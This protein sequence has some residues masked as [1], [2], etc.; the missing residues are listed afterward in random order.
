M[1]APVCV[2]GGGLT[3]AACALAIAHDGWDV[4][5]VDRNAPKRSP[6][7]LGVEIR[8]VALSPASRRL[9]EDLGAWI[10]GAPYKSMHVWEERGTA[11]ID[12]DADDAGVDTLGWIVEVGAL[13]EQL[14]DTAEAHPR[15]QVLE[16][17][18]IE[19]LQQHADDVQLQ[20]ASGATVDASLVVAADGANSRVR[21]LTGT[22]TQRFETGHSALV[23]V[24]RT[25]QPHGEVA[26]QRFLETGPLA[27]LPSKEPNLCS[28][29]WSLPPDFAARI[30]AL[31]DA[32]FCARLGQASEQA[33]GQ[34][35]ATD[36]R[37]VFPLTQHVASNFHAAP[38]VL[39]IGDAARVVH[40]LAGLGVNLG[41]EDVESLCASLPSSGDPI[42]GQWERFARR[43]RARSQ[44][45]VR[46]MSALRMSYANDSPWFGWARNVGVRMVAGNAMV[47]RQ[48]MREA[49]GLGPIA[50]SL[51]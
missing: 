42:N 29:V 50:T 3:G 17:D 27:L 34:V 44:A 16:G 25:E 26:Y 12:F 48:I 46:L 23:T 5:L 22:K 51:R 8:N 37:F 10:G 14:W 43:R 1:D 15:V 7:N 36:Q 30:A 31:A 45:M 18:G 11:A 19:G 41:F 38:R 24:V 35:E 32:D 28:I 6:A 39:L 9:L 33:L 4:V 40:P 47:R 49:I 21:E 20:L 2:V 13:N